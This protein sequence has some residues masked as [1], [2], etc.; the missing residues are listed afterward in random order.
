MIEKL[1]ASQF[2]SVSMFQSISRYQNVPTFGFPEENIRQDKQP[3]PPEGPAPASPLQGLAAI[4][5][6]TH[7]HF[8]Q[9]FT[10]LHNFTP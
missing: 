4:S 10:G 9:Y 2:V 1:I 8:S 5:P 6:Q 3:C 7:T